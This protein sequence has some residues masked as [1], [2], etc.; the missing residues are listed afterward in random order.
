MTPP[1]STDLIKLGRL[2]AETVSGHDVSRFDEIIAPSY[3]NHNAGRG[4][5]VDRDR[6]SGACRTP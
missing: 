1:M 4:A 5:D 3:V 2:F 6:D